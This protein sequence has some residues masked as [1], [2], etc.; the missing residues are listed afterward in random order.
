MKSKLSNRKIAVKA[1]KA[2]AQ[3][4]WNPNLFVGFSEEE[5]KLVKYG[6]EQAL[7]WVYI[8]RGQIAKKVTA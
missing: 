1:V 4:S 5:L 3:T 7:N 8:D 2:A 6:F